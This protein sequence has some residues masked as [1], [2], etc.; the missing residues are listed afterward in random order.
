[1]P[2]LK[3][4]LEQQTTELDVAHARV[5]QLL[6][7]TTTSEDAFPDQPYYHAP[8]GTSPIPDEIWKRL[9][10]E[11]VLE[12]LEAI[13]TDIGG[14]GHLEFVGMFEVSD[15]ERAALAEAA[16]SVAVRNVTALLDDLER[17]AGLAD[18]AVSGR[19]DA[20]TD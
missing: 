16:G 7:E 6:E 17:S 19:A 13:K 9:N 11:N 10:S 5:L 12:T 3:N 8:D 18:D 15:D 14:N 4:M 2:Q 20:A 1:M